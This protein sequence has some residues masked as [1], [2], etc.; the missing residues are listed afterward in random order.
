MNIHKPIIPI[1]LS[2]LSGLPSF[3]THD[4]QIHQ[5]PAETRSEL[6]YVTPKSLL[7]A[8]SPNKKSDKSVAKVDLYDKYNSII[9]DIIS[10]FIDQPVE[11]VNNWY[12]VFDP[13]SNDVM[14]TGLNIG[15][16]ESVLSGTCLKIPDSFEYN[17]KIYKPIGILLS[18]LPAHDRLESVYFP[19]SIRYI[20]QSAFEACGIKSVSLPENLEIISPWAFS[21]NDQLHEIIF[22]SSLKMINQFAFNECDLQSV[23]I[24]DGVE[25]ITDG[26]FRSNK[27]LS[28]VHIGSGLHEI[29]MSAFSLCPITKATIADNHPVYK[30]AN[31]TWLV[32]LDGK[33]LA[34]DFN[35]L[36]ETAEDIPEGVETIKSDVFGTDHP[37]MRRLVCP[38]SLKD[39]GNLNH[40]PMLSEI[41]FN[42]KLETVRS[43]ANTA[44]KELRIPDSVINWADGSVEQCPNL[45]R[46]VIGKNL[47]NLVSAFGGTSLYSVKASTCPSFKEYVIDPENR[48]YTA[49]N[50]IVYTKDMSVLGEVVGTGNLDKISSKVLTVGDLAFAH[51]TY[52]N[53]SLPPNTWQVLCAFYGSSISTLEIPWRTALLHSEAFCESNISDINIHSNTPPVINEDFSRLTSKDIKFH[54]PK[55]S[56]DSYLNAPYWKDFLITDDLPVQENNRID[57]GYCGN[58]LTLKNLGINTPPAEFA[59]KLTKETIRAYKGCTIAAVQFGNSYSTEGY[60]FIYKASTGERVAYQEIFPLCYAMRTQ[61]RFDTPYVITGEEDDDLLVGVGIRDIGNCTFSQFRHPEGNYFRE[62]PDGEWTKGF[63]GGYGALDITCSIEGTTLPRDARV[64]SV[65]TDRIVTEGVCRVKAVVQNTSTVPL[66]SLTLDYSFTAAAKSSAGIKA[67]AKAQ[68]VSGETEHNIYISPGITTEIEFE[69]PAPSSIG[70]YTFDLH[71]AKIDGVE[72]IIRDIDNGTADVLV[73]RQSSFNRKVVMEEGT[74]TWCGYCPEGMATILRM[75]E[76]YPDNFIAVAIHDDDDMPV[77]GNYA[78]ILNSHFPAL[79][80]AA[81]NRK[82]DHVFTPSVSETEKAISADLNIAIG[83][84]SAL[85]NFTSSNRTSI[86]VSTETIL[87]EDATGTYSIACA[88]VENNVGPFWQNAYGT[89]E[90]FGLDC[91]FSRMIYNDVARE[92]YYANE[93][94]PESAITCTVPMEVLSHRITIPVPAN[95]VNTDN[96]ELVA[97]LINNSTGEIENADC[98]TVGAPAGISAPDTDVAGWPAEVYT[99]QGVKVLSDADRSDLETLA[100]GVY[101]LRHLNTTTKF[102][103]K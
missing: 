82:F 24:P 65:E 98:V 87:G 31:D 73:Q 100:P 21:R 27:N 57:L 14:I 15:N 63:C 72:D 80:L 12:C 90:D 97:M 26:A 64:L 33:E 8:A 7:S 88:V 91:D 28:K 101:I 70:D 37:L 74:G 25:F 11:V 13:N 22:P 85:A 86:D 99:L 59:V 48:Y 42:D 46:I 61:I 44:I 77:R 81:L 6:F 67:P 9:N 56:A 51:C 10:P 50:N 5:N 60:A 84:I 52:N 94:S 96:I 4:N 103:K 53:L 78:G 79:P 39:L 55:G 62:L 83:E 36:R 43:F 45:E 19:N 58:H 20:G 17:N 71:V 18:G 89:P 29:N 54:V 47:K 95:V 93:G 3:A 76:K 34:G 30:I 66:S 23:S 92:L 38:S 16:L 1:L 35:S 69:I 102:V 2:L 68:A 32:S 75:K 41:V 49:R 40:S